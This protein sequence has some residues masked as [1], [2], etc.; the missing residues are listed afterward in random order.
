MNSPPDCARSW[1]QMHGGPTERRRTHRF[2]T[3]AAAAR[4]LRSTSLA[5]CTREH[6]RFCKRRR[7]RT[8]SGR[9]RRSSD[10]LRNRARSSGRREPASGLAVARAT[11]CH[12]ARPRHTWS[13]R[14]NNPSDSR[15]IVERS[16]GNVVCAR[17]LEARRASDSQESRTIAGR[18]SPRCPAISDIR[19]RFALALVSASSRERDG[20]EP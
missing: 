6:A 20:R 11:S 14:S 2:S 7:L 9:E 4:N 16:V 8:L 10:C 18:A 12:L 17:G 19:Q 5:G 3:R 1:T 13:Q 15:R